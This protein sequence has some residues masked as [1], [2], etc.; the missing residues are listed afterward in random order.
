MTL[1]D[2]RPMLR[3][4]YQRLSSAN[5]A[6]AYID[7]GAEAGWRAAGATVRSWLDEP[8]QP[9]LDEVLES[10]R[11][12]HFLGV[13]QTTKRATWRW[14]TEQRSLDA[15]EAAHD[16]GLFVALRT[17]PSNIRGL[18]DAHGFDFGRYRE[19]G[20]STYYTQP[21][22]PTREELRV[23][24][25][26]IV[27]LLRSPLSHRCFDRCFRSYLDLGLPVLE[28]PFA[29]DVQRYQPVH[30]G[31]IEYDAAFV[32]GCWPFKWANMERYVRALQRGLGS[33]FAVYGKGWPEGVAK[34]ELTEEAFGPTVGAATVNISLHEPTQ[35]AGF[36]FAPNERV[37]KLLALGACVV[38]DP[39]PMLADLFEGGA[40][41][42]LASDPTDMCAHV[43]ALVEDPAEARRIADA[44]H[45]RVL[46]D[47]TYQRRAERLLEVSCLTDL[48]TRG[49]I[50]CQAPAG[51]PL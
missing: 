37:F 26:G 3:V 28:E 2:S 17:D 30:A 10:F 19:A 44:G 6:F 9:T 20:V 32:G 15:L 39:N 18:F 22:R 51:A 16:D 34:G 25:R 33:R 38:S 40:E 1:P 11:P 45:E 8:G 36:A 7:D 31:P 4:L 24:E 27:D 23:F 42:V 29:A 13:L 41:I 50:P 12:T 49:V 47:H 21:D 5:N 43:R 35:V 46:R 14:M 48:A